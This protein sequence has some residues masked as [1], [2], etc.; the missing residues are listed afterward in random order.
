VRFVPAE[1]LT[2]AELYVLTERVALRVTTWLRKHGYAKEDDHESNDTPE[3]SRREA[4]L[5]GSAARHAREPQGRDQRERRTRRARGPSSRG[6]RDAPRVQPAR[7]HHHRRGRRLGQREALPLR[8]E[9]CVFTSSLARFR[10]LRDGRISYRIKKSARRLSRCR[11]MTPVEC[12]ARLCALVPPHRYPLTRFHGVL[13]PA[14]N[15]DHAS[16]RSS[17]PRQ[18]AHAPHPS[19]R[20]RR[21]RRRRASPTSAPTPS[22][23]ARRRH[24]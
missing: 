4:R 2:R 15:S 8:L 9:A 1:A 23:S 18:C 13:A 5:R 16:S 14:R 21:P 11:I 10:L 19:R 6:C 24:P 20:P 7:E 3:R 22:R 17:R 12:I